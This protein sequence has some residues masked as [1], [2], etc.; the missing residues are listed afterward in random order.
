[1]SFQPAFPS[2]LQHH[3]ARPAALLCALLGA[4]LIGCGSDPA[5]PQAP[6][7][8]V[9]VASVRASELNTSVRLVGRTEAVDAVDLRARVTGFLERR[10]FEEGSDVEKGALLFEIERAPYLA[11]VN[12]AA[13]GVADAEA[14]LANARQYQKRLRSVQAGAVSGAELDAA[15]AAVRE[16]EA[17][18]E[19][20]RANVDSARINLGY[21]RIT[22]PIHGR[23]GRAA[24]TEGN[25]VGPESGVLTTLVRLDPIFVTFNASERDVLDVRQEALA[26]SE[27]VPTFIPRLELA[28]GTQYPHVGEVGF[29]DNR[30]D[31]A[32]GTVTIRA[33]FPNPDGLLLPGQFVTVIAERQQPRSV[34]L[35]PQTAI[36]QTQEGHSVLVVGDDNKVA[37]RKVTLGERS[38]REW[39]V[40]SGLTAGEM[41][42]VGGTQKVRAGIEVNPTPAETPATPA[43]SDGEA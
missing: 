41:V 40:K 39:V 4:A 31:P 30:V 38:G 13:A 21:T 23:I 25:L 10:A 24:V 2:F 15:E 1:M 22:A 6:P 12:A 33:T 17:G 34:L 9:T 8:A 18:L 19:A 28:N 43:A 35:V 27:E 3:Y 29:V 36:Q 42:I 32:T 16:A 5:P 14:S 7:P 11:A 20:A 26:Q 37:S